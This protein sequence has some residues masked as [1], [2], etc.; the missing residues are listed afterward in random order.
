ML[1]DVVRAAS[2]SPDELERL[3]SHARAGIAD[4]RGGR[5]HLAEADSVG[6]TL[7]G[8]VAA[9][10]TGVFVARIDGVPVGFACVGT[11]PTGSASLEA[12]F[13]EP[14]AREVG[15]GEMLAH[16][17]IKWAKGHGA[18]GIDSVALPGDRE[19][20]NFFETFGLVARAIVV[21]RS[22]V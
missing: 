8:R 22:I 20:K 5:Q 11:R 1:L 7:L 13:I 19:T 6:W 15:A 9:A 14:E 21:H 10:D 16:A 18:T 4:E 2:V 3:E 12:L 17:A